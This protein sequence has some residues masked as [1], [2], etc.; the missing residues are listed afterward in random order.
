MIKRPLLANAKNCK[1]FKSWSLFPFTTYSV[2][3]INGKSLS[4]F[5]FPS[6][7]SRVVL[8][9]EILFSRWYDVAPLYWEDSKSV[10]IADQSPSVTVN[11]V[12]ERVTLLNCK[13]VPCVSW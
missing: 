2:P 10:F 9:E 13:T 3:S 11:F 7:K 8:V 12:S 6:V 1:F 4:I 5:S